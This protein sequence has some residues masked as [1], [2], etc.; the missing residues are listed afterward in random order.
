M[1]MTDLIKNMISALGQLN[2]ELLSAHYGS[3]MPTPQVATTMVRRANALLRRATMDVRTAQAQQNAIED[4]VGLSS[5][6]AVLRHVARYT[7]QNSTLCVGPCTRV[8]HDQVDQIKEIAQKLYGR[9]RVAAVRDLSHRLLTLPA[10]NPNNPRLCVATGIPCVAAQFRV[11]GDVRH[12]EGGK[13]HLTEAAERTR[14]AVETAQEATYTRDLAH[15]TANSQVREM[16]VGT[17]EPRV[18]LN[19]GGRAPVSSHAT[20]ENFFRLYSLGQP[21]DTPDMR[22]ALKTMATRLAPRARVR[23]VN[24]LWKRWHHQ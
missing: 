7:V 4:E 1:K 19:G 6:A 8:P 14:L 22:V 2:A 16:E 12:T 9:E 11:S 18:K 24:D 5:E 20:V 23:V 13:L 10:H 21:V 17:F 15:A 3:T